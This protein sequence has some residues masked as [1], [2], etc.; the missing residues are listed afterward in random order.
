MNKINEIYSFF[1]F[2]NLKYEKVYLPF[3]DRIYNQCCLKDIG[4][5]YTFWFDHP[6]CYFL[7]W[8]I[9]YKNEKDKKFLY[10]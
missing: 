8:E 5:C 10:L 3:L 9:Y 4:I 7:L 6:H 2:Y 1:I